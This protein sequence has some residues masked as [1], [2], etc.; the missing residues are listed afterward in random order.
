M[1]RYFGGICHFYAI[2]I[3]V[4]DDAARQE[5]AFG[6]L[7]G[8]R[9]ISPGQ[10]VGRSSDAAPV[11][12]EGGDGNQI[13]DV[14]IFDKVLRLFPD[15]E[16]FCNAIRGE[17]SYT[18]DTAHDEGLQM[19]ILGAEYGM[20]SDSLCLNSEGF[21]IMGHCHEVRLGRQFISGASPVSV[22]KRT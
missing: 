11:F 9:Q 17:V 16:K 7:G 1:F 8:L 12:I 4:H 2:E 22:C 18:G 21:N 13:R 20:H 5:K 14:D 6:F 19:G 10:E 3:S 15:V